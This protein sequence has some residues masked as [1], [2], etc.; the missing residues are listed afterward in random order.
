MCVLTDNVPF[1]LID[2]VTAT[3][4]AVVNKGLGVELGVITAPLPGAVTVKP[5][6][7]SS[8]IK[9][10]WAM[11]MMSPQALQRART[12]PWLMITNWTR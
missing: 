8:K 1:A 6:S 3:Q 9:T 7:C 11:L 2:F 10:K 12:R 4:M 5:A